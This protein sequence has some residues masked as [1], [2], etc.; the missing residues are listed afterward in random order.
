[1]KDKVELP[2]ISILV[3]MYDFTQKIKKIIIGDCS[4][5]QSTLSYVFSLPSMHAHIANQRFRL[6]MVPVQQHWGH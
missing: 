5:K 6:W 4:T 2:N 3:V 1:M